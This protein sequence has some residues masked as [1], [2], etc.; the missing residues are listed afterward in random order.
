MGWYRCR[1]A[2]GCG[3]SQ[4]AVGIRTHN[5]QPTRDARAAPTRGPHNTSYRRHTEHRT[6]A[7]IRVYQKWQETKPSN[8]PPL[9]ALCGGYAI[10]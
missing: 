9:P 6:E 10:N 4:D 1:P 2:L 8:P 7:H 5:H 3:S